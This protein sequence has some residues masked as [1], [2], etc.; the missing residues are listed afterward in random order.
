MV[1]E[2]FVNALWPEKQ[3]Q[4]GSRDLYTGAVVLRCGISRDVVRSLSP[5]SQMRLFLACSPKRG[6]LIERSAYSRYYAGIICF[7]CRELSIRWVPCARQ[8]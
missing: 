8:V 6:R 2:Q 5:W 7:W 1:I 4:V 3:W